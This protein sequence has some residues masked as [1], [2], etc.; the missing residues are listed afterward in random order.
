MDIG[1]RYHWSAS[2]VLNG[3]PEGHPCGRMHGHNYS[4]EVFVAGAIGENGFVIDY[5][6]LDATIGEYIARH[7]DHQHLNNATLFRDGANPTAE[8]IAVRLAEVCGTLL[9]AYVTVSK[10]MI[11]ETERTAAVWHAIR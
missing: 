9:P 4:A 3:L 11:R 8:L 7:L 10:V 6:D 5:H 1:K 2:H